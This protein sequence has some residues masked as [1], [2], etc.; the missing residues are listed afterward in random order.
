MSLPSTLRCTQVGIFWWAEVE[1]GLEENHLA[2]PLDRGLVSS[3]YK[4]V[5]S[6]ERQESVL[7]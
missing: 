2:A 5:L 3:P 4:L 1:I 7:A 6:V